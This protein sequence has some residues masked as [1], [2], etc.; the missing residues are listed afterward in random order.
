MSMYDKTN[1]ISIK[2]NPRNVFSLSGKYIF[3]KHIIVF[4]LLFLCSYRLVVPNILPDVCKYLMD[5]GLLVLVGS[6]I[7][8]QPP[9]M[10]MVIN[11]NKLETMV[12][13]LL[14]LLFSIYL[15]LT[16][17]I[18]HYR[19]DPGML[20]LSLRIY[21]R[22]LIFTLACIKF[23]DCDF[24]DR[25]III[26][27]KLFPIHFALV[28]IQFFFLGYRMDFVSGLF[29]VNIGA[30]MYSNAYMV[31]VTT[32]MLTAWMFH[33]V[34]TSK[35]I[36]MVGSCLIIA[37]LSELKFYY[38]EMITIYLILVILVKKNFRDVVMNIG[39]I[40]IGIGALSIMLSFLYKLY[41][42]F[43]NFMNL[44]SMIEYA[45]SENGY[46]GM[47]DIN[48]LNAFSQV[49]KRIFHG[50]YSKVLFGFGLSAGREGTSVFDSYGILHYSWFTDAY[51]YVECGI[52]GV[53][54]FCLILFYE[55]RGAFLRKESMNCMIA[56]I[57]QIMMGILFVYDE[58]LNTETSYLLFF[59]SAYPFVHNQKNDILKTLQ[60]RRG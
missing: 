20:L 34:S 33:K 51:L 58:T 24:Y 8:H 12:L 45:T 1:E 40:S 36:L 54:L 39:I 38:V 29:G 22:P 41:P 52:I 23:T 25:V 28:L 44:D 7:R 56:L 37:T 18:S 49:T 27:I 35:M 55:I 59:L 21:I 48:R 4:E 53:I 26:L 3:E 32:I 43:E 14:M 15:L 16:P 17:L 9:S 47:G 42:N 30:N 19:A 31:V 50:D 60:S 57:V 11:K 46:T 5:A 2:I 13:S 6:M 10:T